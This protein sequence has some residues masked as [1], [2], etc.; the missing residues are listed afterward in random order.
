MLLA[1]NA[2]HHLIDV[3][4]VSGCWKTAADPVGKALA[5]LQRPLP[6][7]LMADEDAPGGRHLL[8]HPQA[9]RE[10]KYNHTARLITS[11]GKRW[12]A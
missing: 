10:R 9:E 6:H 4:C 8:N 3:P 7:G 2:D 11:A 1:C 5:E 12:R